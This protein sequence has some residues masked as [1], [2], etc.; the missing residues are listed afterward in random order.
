MRT[1]GEI[2]KK[3]RTEK[4]LV[5]EEIEKNLRIRKKFLQALEEN[6]WDRLPSLPYIKGFIR[7]YSNY[8]GLKPEEMIAIF[9]RQ[10]HHSDKTGIIPE[11]ITKPLN[12]PVVKYTQPLIIILTI[13]S[14]IIFFSAYIFLQYQ[15]YINPPNLSIIYPKEGEIVNNTNIQVSGKTDNDAILS[16]NN[17]KIALSQSGDFTSEITLTP[18]INT[19]VIE[20]SSKFGKKRTLTRTVQF[21]EKPN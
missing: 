6:A 4:G 11:G 3:A 7:S 21:V 2:L 18:G 5:F 19:I 14:F 12:E 17:Q 16:I 20:S 1:I 13:I 9:R 15:S 10:S 8:L